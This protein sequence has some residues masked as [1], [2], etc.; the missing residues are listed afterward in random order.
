MSKTITISKLDA[1]R[2]QLETAVRLYFHDG[3]P[4]S[5]HTLVSAAYNVIRDV[6]EKKGGSPMFVKGDFIDLYVKP[7]YR[8]QARSKV[9]KAENFFKHADR[10]HASTIEF[11]PDIS[12][13][14]F[15]DAIGHYVKIAGW[16]PSLFTLFARWFMITH[17]DFFKE[18]PDAKEG[19]FTEFGPKAVGLGRTRFF[20][21]MLPL[22]VERG[23]TDKDRAQK[24]RHI[25]KGRR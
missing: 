9:N 12:E 14:F 13:M 11:N 4:I 18:H 6:N 1:A 3:D 25:R 19:L 20:A 15:Y 23:G 8:K 16:Y 24:I 21:S 5:I 7:E 10:D 17:E 22:I 2:R